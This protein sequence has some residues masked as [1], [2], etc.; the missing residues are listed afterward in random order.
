MKLAHPKGL[1]FIIG[2]GEDK[3]GDCTILAEFVR[4]AGGA[5]RVSS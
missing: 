2:G 1:L 3:E 4:L 5:G